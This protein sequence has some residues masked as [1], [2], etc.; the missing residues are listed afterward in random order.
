MASEA[1]S[2]EEANE[3]LDYSAEYGRS[4]GGIVTAVT[5]RVPKTRFPHYLLMREPQHPA[6][7]LHYE[8]QAANLRDQHVETLYFRSHD[9][10]VQFIKTSTPGRAGVMPS[11]VVRKFVG[12]GPDRSEER[13]VGKEC[14]SRWSPYH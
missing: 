13:R 8:L 7:A 14:R 12:C 1:L 4:T 11:T 10:V 9:D 2:D 6:E 5:R 3:L